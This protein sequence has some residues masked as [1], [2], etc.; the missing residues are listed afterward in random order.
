MGITFDN[1]S[2]RYGPTGSLALDKVGFTL[3]EGS[4]T[5]I[6]GP[7]GSGKTT[8]VSLL[9]RFWEL[10]SGSILVGGHDLRDYRADDLREL[11]GVVPQD[12]YLFNATIRDNLLLANPDATGEQLSA[13]CHTALLD[14]FIQT[15][16]LGFDTIVGEN[17][18]LLSGGERQRLAI[19]RAILKDAPIVLLDEPSANLDTITERRL[20][21]SLQSFL[22]QRT[23]LIISH[24]RIATEYADH[25]IRLERGR[26]VDQ[27]FKPATGVCIRSR[28]AS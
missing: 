16:P 11:F 12:I 17:G 2:F 5:A 26:V 24:R 14:N 27:T 15:L 20:F 19:A 21:Q 28:S 6:V 22:A 4:C 23:T 25:V 13:A 1:L 10:Q 7:S 9:L 8:I 3:S 18:L